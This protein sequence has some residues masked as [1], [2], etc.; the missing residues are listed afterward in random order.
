M[1]LGLYSCFWLVFVFSFCQ[2][3]IHDLKILC[4]RLIYCINFHILSVYSLWVFVAALISFSESIAFLFWFSSI[5][6]CVSFHHFCLCRL[7]L[8]HLDIDIGAVVCVIGVVVKSLIPWTQLD[9]WEIDHF[10]IKS[11][12]CWWLLEA[13]YT[14]QKKKIKRR[15][16][17]IV[18]NYYRLVSNDIS[19]EIHKKRFQLYLF[20]F[21]LSSTVLSLFEWV[22]KMCC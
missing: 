10:W 13:S 7:R 21:C 22:K 5:I 8:S 9:L 19:W 12:C 1:F 3:H 6:I 16:K 2:R 17:Q 15:E 11:L 18:D 4:I 20:L 14:L